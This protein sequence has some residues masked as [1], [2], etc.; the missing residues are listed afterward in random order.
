MGNFSFDLLTVLLLEPRGGS[1]DVWDPYY[2]VKN[3]VSSSDYFLAIM[4]TLIPT[5]TKLLIISVYAPKELSE[6]RHL[7]DYLCSMIGQWE[8]ETVILGDF[9]EVRMEY[10]RFG[11]SF[12]ITRANTFNNFISMDGLLDIPL[13]GYT[14]ILM[15]DLQDLLSIETFEVTQ[16]AKL[17]LEQSED[18]ESFVSY[19]EIKRAVLDYGTNKSPRS[20]GFSFDFIRK[21]WNII[22][23]DV[24][25]AVKDF[26][27]T[28]KFPRG[29]NSS[30]IALI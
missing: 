21:F 22:D 19:D 14:V 3:H 27:A 7:W 29:C 13:G 25:V 30:F 18:L 10:E 6:K 4:G 5:S 11:S 28:A 26:F 2:F 24:V 1:L 16:K 8:G 17:T 23:E 20:D 12:N 15:K 9:N